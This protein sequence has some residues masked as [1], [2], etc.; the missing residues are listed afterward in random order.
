[1]NENFAHLR[2]GGATRWSKVA[3]MARNLPVKE[4]IFHFRAG[5]NVMH[6]HVTAREQRFT[7]Y[8]HSNMSQ[9]A[10]QVPGH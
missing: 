9:S 7:V 6:D 8:N 1:M 5:A 2:L 10:A 3:I 4:H